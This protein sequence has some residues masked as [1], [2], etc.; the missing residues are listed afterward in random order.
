MTPVLSVRGLGHSFA[1]PG[2]GLF[3]G[4]KRRFRAVDDVNFDLPRG[5]ILGVVGESGCGKSTLARLVMRL[6]EPTD[7]EVFFEGNPI[8]HLTRHELRPL[9]RHLQMVFQDPYSSIDPR[10]TIAEALSE[11]LD[12]QRVRMTRAERRAEIERLLALVALDPAMARN[13]PHH[14][15]GGQR[16]RV[17]IARALALGPKLIAFDEPTASLDVSVQAQVVEL[18]LRLRDDLNLTY[19]FISH[20]LALVDYLCDRVMVMY[21]G[22]VVE[23][24]PSR[25]KPRHPYTRALMEAAFVPDPKAR[26]TIDRVTGEIPSG[27]ADVPGCAFAARCPEA[28]AD[29]RRIRPALV[30][31]GRR[32]VACHAAAPAAA[33][34]E[35]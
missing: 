16:Q 1:G 21:L 6:Y 3:G 4:G 31:D 8:A 17:G 30:G 5:E 27:Y 34:S 14:L 2:G 15:S 35:S 23:I 25:A 28:V 11:P 9:R 29:C 33:L 13:H 32:A 18:L 24:L 20:D 22:R 7:G 19:L 26:R 12:V 10:Q